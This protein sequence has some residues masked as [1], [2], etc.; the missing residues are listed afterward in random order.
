MTIITQRKQGKSHSQ[1]LSQLKGLAGK[2]NWN[3]RSRLSSQ[4]L[5]SSVDDSGDSDEGEE[6]PW[7][8]TATV[9]SGTDLVSKDSNGFSDPFVRLALLDHSG[10]TL[11][12]ASTKVKSKT[13]E[14]VWGE[15]F[16]LP[17]IS[18]AHLGR[19]LLSAEVWDKDL[20]GKSEFMG[21]MVLS[22]GRLR[23]QQLEQMRQADQLKPGVPERRQF[24]LDLVRMSDLT[25]HPRPD[26][27]Q[28][29]V[30]GS[31]TLSFSYHPAN[32]DIP[33]AMA[34]R[35]S[36]TF[37][38]ARPSAPR[39]RRSSFLASMLGHRKSK[40]ALNPPPAVAATPPLGPRPPPGPAP[41]GILRAST[42]SS[43]SPVQDDQN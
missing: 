30:S 42:L 25:L 39:S 6:S 22:L 16:Q 21:R 36:S 35:R 27:P 19:K 3:L 12:K 4:A 15:S 10:Q 9:E 18:P 40:Q 11:W 7:N 5:L 37:I 38:N 31:L 23:T 41:P 34:S 14:P 17:P 32:E 13:L 20:I 8:L 33:K 29:E 1:T 43:L 26:N 28:D 24:S 2:A